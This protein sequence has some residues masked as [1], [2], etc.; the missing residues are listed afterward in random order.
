MNLQI[1]LL[2]LEAMDKE[3]M[4]IYRCVSMRSEYSYYAVTI[5]SMS[6][7]MEQVEPDVHSLNETIRSNKVEIA[8]L[9]RE[10]V[11]ECRAAHARV[12]NDH[13]QTNSKMGGIRALDGSTGESA[14]RYYG[15]SHGNA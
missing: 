3:N 7:V 15:R 2:S 11:D 4:M 6:L 9:E 12:N 13:N 5:N 14:G 8:E 10:R 1:A